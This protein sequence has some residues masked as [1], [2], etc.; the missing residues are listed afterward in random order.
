M[1]PLKLDSSQNLRFPG[2]QNEIAQRE[3]MSTKISM[4]LVFA[5]KE[6]CKKLL[7]RYSSRTRRGIEIENI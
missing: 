3:K 1:I 5:V 4:N 7:H 2:P 6:F